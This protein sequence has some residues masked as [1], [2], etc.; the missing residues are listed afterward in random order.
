MVTGESEGNLQKFAS[1]Q[2]ISKSFGLIQ[3]FRGTR[4]LLYKGFK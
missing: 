4:L 3:C 2:Y 1:F